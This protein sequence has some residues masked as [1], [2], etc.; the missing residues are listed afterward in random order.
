MILTDFFCLWIL[1]SGFYYIVVILAVF[2]MFN[3]FVGYLVDPRISRG[4]HKLTRTLRV[5]K[6]SYTENPK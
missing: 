6:K 4:V 3:E 1:D 5:I 2:Y